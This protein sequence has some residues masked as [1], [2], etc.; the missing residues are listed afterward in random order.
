MAGDGKVG[1]WFGAVGPYA[2]VAALGLMAVLGPAIGRPLM[3]APLFPLLRTAV[4]H[5]GWEA[6]AALGVL[7]LVAGL[8]TDLRPRWIG[9]SSI[10][11]LPLAAFAEIAADGTSHNLIPFELAMYAFMALPALLMSMLGRALRR[12]FVVAGPAAPGGA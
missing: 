7:G 2:V 10:A 8:A 12:K 5:V 3:P 9:L 11:A 4:E 6:L 1:R